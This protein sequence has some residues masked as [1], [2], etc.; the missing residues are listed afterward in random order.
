MHHTFAQLQC[1]GQRFTQLLLLIGTDFEAGNRQF[2]G[3]LLESID[4]WKALVVGKKLPST[5]RCV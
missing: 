5:L 1:F 4:T 3:V 2:N